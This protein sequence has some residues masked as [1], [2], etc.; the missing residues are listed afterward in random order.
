MLRRRLVSCDDVSSMTDEDLAGTCLRIA[1]TALE[2]AAMARQPD[3]AHLLRPARQKKHKSIAN[4]T[5]RVDLAIQAVIDAQLKAAFP[6]VLILG[7]EVKRY[8]KNLAAVAKDLV[9]IVDPVDGTDLLARG[10]SNWC[11]SLVMFSPKERRIR[12]AVVAHSD[13]D[14]Y[15]AT[16]DGAFKSRRDGTGFVRSKLAVQRPHG[17]SLAQASVCFYG[18]KPERIVSTANA[19]RFEAMQQPSDPNSAKFRIYNL[20]GNPMMVK[21][22]DGDVDIVFELKGQEVH[23]VLP[24]AFIALHAG[25][26]IRG[27][28]KSEIELNRAA[29]F[30]RERMRYVLAATSRLQEEFS[31]LIKSG[32]AETGVKTAIPR[33]HRTPKRRVSV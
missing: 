24:G 13:G 17:F 3:K 27:V 1:S 18:Q 16:E 19:L 25:A 14:L 11:C 6:S 28:D 2:F 12:A 20:G 7:E 23:D 21:I 15:W 22:P 4:K 9:A 8:P 29:L 31:S 10:F 32:G 30:P 5:R 33:I 26:V